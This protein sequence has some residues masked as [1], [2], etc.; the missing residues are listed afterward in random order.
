MKKIFVAA[1]LFIAALS[2]VNAQDIASILARSSAA[3]YAKS[4]EEN[5]SR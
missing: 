4:W 1:V 2:G 3:I 5:I